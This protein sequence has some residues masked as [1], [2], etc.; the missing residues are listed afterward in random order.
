MVMA[1]TQRHSGA[2][3]RFRRDG[4]LVEWSY[5]HFGGRVRDLARGLIARG[6]EAGDRVAILGGTAPEWTLVDCAVLS[7]GAV[8]VPIY[9]TNSPQ[10]CAYVLTHSEARAVIVEDAEQLAKIEQVRADCPALEQVLAMHPGLGVPSIAE[11]GSAAGDAV[12][13]ERI[14]AAQPDDMATIVYTS[15]TTG[16]PKGCVLTH[17]NCLSTLEMYEQQLEL[18]GD[19]VIFMFLPLAHV[20]ARVTELVA[21]DVG[22][23]L[24]FW[25]G[26]STRLLEDIAES[27][28]THFPSVPRVFEKIHTRAVAGV[29]DA[30]GVKRKLF[31][32]ALAV[33]ARTRAAQRTG[34]VDPLLRA[35]HAVADR[36]VLSKVRALFGGRLE[37]ALTGAAPIAADVLEFFDACGVTLLEAYGLTESCAAGTLNTPHALRPGTV[38]RA[39][40]GTGVQIGK[41]GEIL[42]SGPH[43]FHGYHRDPEATDDALEDGWLR[44]GDLGAI[45]VDGFLRITGRIKDLIITSSGKNITPSNIESGLRESRWISQAVVHGD[46]RPYLVALLTLDPEEA[47]A[48]ARE[49]GIAPDIASMATDERV[50]AVLGREVDAVNERFAR[51]ERIKR[52]AVLDHDLTLAGGELTPT[53]KVKRAVVEA[54]YRDH[55]AA[56]YE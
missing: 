17:G 43:V 27:A 33:G 13:Q 51:I 26:D 48:L 2:A 12:L 29:E 55:F 15:G 45:D 50:L 5:A 39:L 46:R 1:A 18:S 3:I 35:Q 24:A 19:V 11:I 23:T 14:A 53:L 22:G 56:L 54:H 31:D 6:I 52:F 40:P 21:L 36:L 44:T 20:L 32:W 30:G 7:A 25:S 28:P 10:E 8:T 38:G 9:Q 16:P 47:P 42:L 41:G 34:G 49:L 37:L 4:Q